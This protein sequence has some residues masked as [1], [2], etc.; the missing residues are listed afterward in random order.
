MMCMVSEG[1]NCSKCGTVE[2]MFNAPCSN[3][4]GTIYIHASS[5]PEVQGH[6]HH[7]ECRACHMRV[8]R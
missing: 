6:G 8:S 2:S 5:D 1:Y 3:C 4:G 7:I